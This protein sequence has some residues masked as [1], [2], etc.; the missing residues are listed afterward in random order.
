MGGVVKKTSCEG[1]VVGS[2]PT[3]S[4]AHEKSCDFD[5][6]WWT[7]PHLI[8][9]ILVAYPCI[10][11]THNNINVNYPPK[12]S[13]DFLLI[14]FALCIIF[15]WT[16]GYH[17]QQIRDPHP[18]PPPLPRFRRAGGEGKVAHEKSCDFDGDRWT[19]PHLIKI[20]LVAYPCVATTHN[21]INVNYPPKRSQDFLLIIFALCII[22]LW[23][24]RYHGQQIRDPHPSP[25]PLPRFRRAGGEGK[26]QTYLFVARE[27]HNEDLDI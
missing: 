20:I 12:R 19:R 16:H 26:I 8:K 17:R 1:E 4:V 6:D 13:Q 25:P 15:L 23:M 24:H 5:G 3:H 2:I 18:S 22:F 9:I 7:R 11:M 14:I 10:A 21:N 27:G